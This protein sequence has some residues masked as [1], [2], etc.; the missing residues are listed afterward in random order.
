MH[1]YIYTHI[2]K[3]PEIVSESQTLNRTISCRVKSRYIIIRFL[4]FNIENRSKIPI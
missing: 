3:A 4:S 2:Y 1:T